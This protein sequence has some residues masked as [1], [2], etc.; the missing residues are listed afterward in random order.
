M[1]SISRLTRN[2]AQHA[3]AA[4]PNQAIAAASPVKI[5]VLLSGK[6]EGETTVQLHRID[7]AM[8]AISA[9]YLIRQPFDR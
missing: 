8:R 2:F 4:A 9:R 7:S 5:E 3:I 1:Q 6:R